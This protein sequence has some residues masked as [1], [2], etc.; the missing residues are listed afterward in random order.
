MRHHSSYRAVFLALGGVVLAPAAAHPQDPAEVIITTADLGG[1]VHF[2]GG[3]GG[4]LAAFAGQDGV[5]L[6]DD[7]YAPM[8]DR[9][10]ATV[11]TISS[12][13]IRFV[14]NT[15]WHGDHTGGNENLGQ[16]GAVLVGGC[17]GSTP[18]HIRAFREAMDRFQM[19]KAL[20]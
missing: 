4:N 7:Q 6:V 9:I 8:T 18:D 3:R 17:C 12:Q 11:A 20:S 19:A 16:A 1:G 15:H 10:L 5:F 13:P 2:I 14:L